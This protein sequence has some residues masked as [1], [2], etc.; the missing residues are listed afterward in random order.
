MVDDL[1][2]L[3]EA[4]SVDEVIVALPASAHEEVVSVVSMCERHGVGLKLVPDLF[5]MSLSRVQVDDISGIPLLDVQDRTF[6]RLARLGKRCVDLVVGSVVL[7]LSL[8]LLALLALLIRLESPGPAFLRQERVGLGGR[9]F[10]CLKLRTMRTEAGD[11]EPILFETAA[12]MRLFKIRDDPRCT[13]VG[14]R[15]RRWSLDELPQVWNV[16]MGD[17]SLV[18]PR[19]PLPSQVAKYEPKH[20]RR[21]DVKPGMTGLWQVSGRSDLSFDE[22]VHMDIYYVENW[23]LMLDFKLMIRTVIAVLG[24]R[25]AY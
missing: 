7:V 25:G 20:W 10:Q 5:E 16:L 24:R 1:P 22:M 12:D 2:A 4:G 9:K 11:M 23:T 14:R 6:R 13:R 15:I 8:P 18:G 3:I 17:M 21:L 19:P